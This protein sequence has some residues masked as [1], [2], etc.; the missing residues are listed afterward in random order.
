MTSEA[1]VVTA[2]IGRDRERKELEAF[3]GATGNGP[4]AL[5][6]EGEPG[7]GK[8]TLWRA[9]I[10]GARERGF[11]VLT[12]RPAEAEASLSFAVLGDLLAEITDTI[13]ELPEPQRRA[14]RIALL[15]EEHE[16]VVTDA[17]AVSVALLGLLRRLAHEAPVLVAVDDVQWLDAPTAGALTFALRRVE[18]DRVAFLGTARPGQTQLAIETLDRVTVGPLDPPA[19]D[20]IVRN[21][22]EARL[23]RPVLRRLGQASGGNPF[24]ALEL[25]RGL[26]LHERQLGPTDP[27]PLPSG[28]GDLLRARLAVLPPSSRRALPA[29]AA[30]AQPTRQLI[31]RAVGA[32]AQGLDAARDAGVVEMEGGTVR[33]THPLLASA[34]YAEV[35]PIRRRELHRGLA[36]VV[37]D[38][39]E[40]ARH[41]ALAVEPPDA[42]VADALEE[43]ATGAFERGA[44]ESAAE[45]IEHALRFTPAE[46]AEPLHRRRLAGAGYLARTGAKTRARE[47]LLQAGSVAPPG[48]DRARIALTAAWYGLLDSSSSIEGLRDAVEH[49]RDDKSLLLKVHSLLAPKLLYSTDLAGA[50]HHAAK[51]LELAE[52]IGDDAH[53][54]LALIGVA[55]VAFFAGQGLDLQRVE[56]AVELEAVA[57]NPYGN[58]GV[59]RGFLG[60]SLSTAGELE[61]ARQILEEKA[62][63]ERRRGDIGISWTLHE[64]ARVEIRAGNWERAQILAEESLDIAREVGDVLQQALAYR[65]LTELAVLHGDACG[66]REL[67]A[68]GLRL[69]DLGQTPLTRAE[70]EG[71]MGQLE[72]SLDDGAAAIAHLEQVARIKAKTGFREPG[73]LP[74]T[75]DYIEALIAV[76]DLEKAAVATEELESQGIRLKRKFTV[77]AAARCGGQLAAAGGDLAAAVENLADA[78]AV[79]AELGQP[80]ELARTLLVQGTI[81]RRARRV[82]EARKTLNQALAL[83]EEL[84]ATRWA[85]R[86]RRE[87]ARLGGRPSQT[88][89]L[90]P[91]EQQVADLVASGKSNL[92]VA[93]ALHVSPKT[94]EWNLSKVYK[95]LRVSS[96]TELAAKLAVRPD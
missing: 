20:F 51:A 15:L 26:L 1:G 4:K 88:A 22:L 41:L 64:L 54:V 77:A 2:L 73:I 8:T 92:D 17:R 37:S 71:S 43:A 3:L 19:I 82:A 29:V 70:M 76:G 35:D 39:E 67:A 9:G 80:F 86:A 72:L 66:A 46:S 52:E 49:A 57:G 34:V 25:A 47:V 53:L 69:A 55:H 31:E 85:Q 23:A 61:P 59:A 13:G 7:I 32:D 50:E 68:E 18:S 40:R 58:V 24:Y 30:L 96:R 89:Q 91:T 90:T 60:V 45:L 33:F 65:P 63:E 21:A 83:F 74:F 79:A 38:P 48:P 14:L 6:L 28:L 5:L 95:K 10:D 93:H 11:R 16:G 42:D 87:L 62:A 81:F 12:A 27:V 44:T 94:V 56:R 36:E 84:G 78:R 75:P